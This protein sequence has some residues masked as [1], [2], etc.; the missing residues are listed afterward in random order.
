[1]TPAIKKNGPLREMVVSELGEGVGSPKLEL[2]GIGLRLKVKGDGVG[3]DSAQSGCASS[4][5]NRRP[6][7]PLHQNQRHALH[8]KKRAVGGILD[9]MVKNA[10]LG[11]VAVVSAYRCSPMLRSESSFPAQLHPPIRP[12]RLAEN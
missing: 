7:N 1:M 6:G 8:A 2:A 10:R 12:R 11:Q 9:C 5:S 4:C 3:S